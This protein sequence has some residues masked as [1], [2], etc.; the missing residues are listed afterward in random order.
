MVGGEKS[1][2][3]FV[4]PKAI[5][6]K[7]PSLYPQRVSSSDGRVAEQQRESHELKFYVRDVRVEVAN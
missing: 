4:T 1:S 2:N 7:K 6:F 3:R 5:D